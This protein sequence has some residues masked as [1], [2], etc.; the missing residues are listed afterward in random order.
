MCNE[1]EF[2]IKLIASLLTIKITD[3][4]YGYNLQRNWGSQ[5]LRQT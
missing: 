4:F 2:G 3:Q 5:S 1:N